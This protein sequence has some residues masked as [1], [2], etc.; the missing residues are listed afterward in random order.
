MAGTAGS[1]ASDVFA[2]LMSLANEQ[3][4]AGSTATTGNLGRQ[5]AW[6]GDGQSIYFV[7][8]I[9]TAGGLGGLY[10]ESVTGG[11][12]VKLLAATDENT[13]PAVT[14]ANGVDSIYF[15]GGGTTGNLGGIDK[16][17]YD[18]TTASARQVAIAAS[19]IDDFLELPAGTAITTLSMTSDAAGDLFFNDT[20]S[21][22]PGIYEYDTLGRLSKV[23]TKAERQ[24][25][26]GSSTVTVNANTLK[27]ADAHDQLRRRE[28]LVPHHAADVRRKHAG[29]HRGGG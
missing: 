13:E 22:R 27:D 7:D 21:N 8:A 15:R 5:F 16:I 18:G 12:P 19:T 24:A 28:R 6:S 4:A 20:S 17:T 3:T 10:K 29:Q 1:S 14:T 23:V 11:A 26:F 9:T 25:A 2:P